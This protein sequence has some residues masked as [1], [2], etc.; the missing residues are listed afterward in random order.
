MT[1]KYF[2]DMFKKYYNDVYNFSFSYLHDDDLAKDIVQETFA[3][4]YY[5]PPR[6]KENIKSWLLSVAANKCKDYFRREKRNKTINLD[7]NKIDTNKN[8]NMRIDVMH[9][10]DMLPKKYELSI[11][12]FYYGHCSIEEIAKKLD[13]SNV[14]VK[15]RLE[16]GR[17]ML[18]KYMEEEN[19][20]N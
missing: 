9:Y 1:E 11:R 20:K 10:I 16:R 3:I 17:G 13:I 2:D 4:F 15:K 19:E 14:A 18:K 6:D 7:T 8:S 12:L 5:K